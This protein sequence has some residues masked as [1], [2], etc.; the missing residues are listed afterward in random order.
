MK[1]QQAKYVQSTLKFSDSSIVTL[2]GSY[3]NF[4]ENEKPRLTLLMKT[5]IISFTIYHCFGV[6]YY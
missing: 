6:N 2:D 5:P 1:F 4:K 3:H